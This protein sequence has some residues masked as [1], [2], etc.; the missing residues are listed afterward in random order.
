MSIVPGTW[1]SDWPITYLFL[2]S[3][4]KVLDIVLH[5]M[6]SP[7]RSAQ[8][9]HYGTSSGHLCTTVLKR[10]PSSEYKC[11]KKTWLYILFQR[12][13]ARYVGIHGVT[14]CDQWFG[15]MVMNLKGTCLE[16]WWQEMWGSGMWIDFSEWARNV[17]RL[18]SHL[19]PRASGNECFWDHIR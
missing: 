12:K 14:D 13:M 7:P 8:L 1:C 3:S 6:H 2:H 11:E 19:M 16:N 4:H 5:D 9:H 10:N 15:W 18:V 17:K